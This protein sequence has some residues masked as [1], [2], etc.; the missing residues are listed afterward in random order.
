V[1]SS[2]SLTRKPKQ[3]TARAVATRRQHGA[4]PS[5]WTPRATCQSEA[6]FVRLGR[7]PRG[8]WPLPLATTDARAARQGCGRSTSRA[9][10]GSSAAGREHGA[11]WKRRPTSGRR[12]GAMTPR[13]AFFPL[14]PTLAECSKRHRWGGEILHTLTPRGR[15]SVRVCGMCGAVSRTFDPWHWAAAV[16]RRGGLPFFSQPTHE[17]RRA[18]SS[19]PLRER[20]LRVVGPSKGSGAG[21]GPSSSGAT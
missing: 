9:P 3:S 15:V 5:C 8:G 6:R 13:T 2:D 17:K 16:H 11:T 21:Q 18:E 7:M 12:A 20:H 19:P 4:A 14:F 10:H 1:C